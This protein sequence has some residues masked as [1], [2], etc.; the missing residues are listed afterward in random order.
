MVTSERNSSNGHKLITLIVEDNV[1]FRKYFKESLQNRFPS[2]VIEEAGDGNEVLE[3]VENLCPA[4]IFMDIRLPGE[5][6]LQLT[7]KIKKSHSDI[8]IIILT[9]YDLPEYRE[10]AFQYGANSFMTKDSLNWGEIDA[11]IKSISPDS[12]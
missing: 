6:G 12:N 3:K 11:L 2:M 7:K 9:T 4:L 1:S 10:A 8:K 5:N